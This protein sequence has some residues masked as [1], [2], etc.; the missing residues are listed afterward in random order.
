ME[1]IQLKDGKLLISS[2]DL[3]ENHIGIGFPNAGIMVISFSKNY[4]NI[5]QR[6]I[7]GFIPLKIMEVEEY[8]FYFEKNGLILVLIKTN[9]KYIIF[10][11]IEVIII[12]L[13]LKMLLI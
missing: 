11:R 5:E 4:Y 8:I 7:C 2:Y 13:I 3:R 12:I 10:K 1:L 9:G 6:L